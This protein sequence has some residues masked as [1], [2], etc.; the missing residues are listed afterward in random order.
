MTA[1][2]FI[3][4][5]FPDQESARKAA[6]ALTG[7]RLAA[8]VNILPGMQSF[9]WWEGKIDSAAEVVLIAKA[10]AENFE[11]VRAHIQSLHPYSCPCIIALPIA[12]G[13]AP[14]LEWIDQE[15]SARRS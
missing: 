6:M 3:Y 11:A 15:T 9:Y 14:F 4:S 10:P 5:T 1:Y 13:H 7:E 12:A 2:N 8:C